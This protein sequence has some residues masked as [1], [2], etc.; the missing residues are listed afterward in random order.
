VVTGSPATNS[1]STGAGNDRIDVRDMR[2]DS[3]DCGAG[4]DSDRRLHLARLGPFLRKCLPFN[5]LIRIA[6]HGIPERT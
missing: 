4:T 5:R 3:V 1:I 2:A 6:V